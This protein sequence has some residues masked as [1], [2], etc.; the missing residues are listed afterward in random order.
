[1]RFEHRASR[2]LALCASDLD[3]P[4]LL[5]RVI[6]SREQPTHAVETEMLVVVADKPQPLVVDMGIEPFDGG[7]V[8]GDF[9]LKRVGR[10][11]FSRCFRG[12]CSPGAG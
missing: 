3:G 9:N 7:G 2:A 8:I 12:F 4:K 10:S 6:E 1:M 5:M 11:L